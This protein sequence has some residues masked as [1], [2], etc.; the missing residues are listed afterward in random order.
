[1]RLYFLVFFD[2]HNHPLES[3]STLTEKRTAIV[4][5]YLEYH[6]TL[7]LAFIDLLNLIFLDA[8][9]R[10]LKTFFPIKSLL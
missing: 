8:K 1:M 2:S 9:Y 7:S 10:L 4:C 6:S 3:L 5:K